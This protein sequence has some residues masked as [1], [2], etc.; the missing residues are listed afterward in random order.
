MGSEAGWNGGRRRGN[1]MRP[2]IDNVDASE[3]GA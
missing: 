3:Q 2:I 1:P